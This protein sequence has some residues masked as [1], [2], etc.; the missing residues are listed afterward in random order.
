MLES[1]YNLALLALAIVGALRTGAWVT[2]QRWQWHW[3]AMAFIAV[4]GAVL[5]FVQ[6]IG[7]GPKSD[8]RI[9]TEVLA[10][11]GAIFVLEFAFRRVADNRWRAVF[12][13]TA[14]VF[15]FVTWTQSVDRAIGTVKAAG[16]GVTT[17]PISAVPVESASDIDPLCEDPN[18]SFRRRKMLDCP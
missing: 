17:T 7:G 1:I 11:A 2:G 5:G 4:T 6:Q 13:A 14:G 9:V 15:L 16:S 8:L 3:K 10:S 18:V 12:V